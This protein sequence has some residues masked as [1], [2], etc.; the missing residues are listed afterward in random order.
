MNR[1]VVSQLI[2]IVLLSSFAASSAQDA[3]GKPPAIRYGLT[4][5]YR[6]AGEDDFKATQKYALECFQEEET[7]N[8]LY[9]TQTGALSVLSKGLFKAGEG[10]EKGPLS[11]H[12]FEITVRKADDK[13]VKFGVECFLDENNK[14]LIYISQTGS[15][16]VV[17]AKYAKPTT[18]KIKG[19]SRSHGMNLKVR[20]AGD[21][22]FTKD[23]KKYGIDVV[24]DDN[25][26]NILYISETGSIAAVPAALLK[27]GGKTDWKDSWQ[28]GLELSVRGP[29]EK[30]FSKDTKKYGVEV[31]R[32]ADNGCMVYI[33]ENGNIA[34]VPSA[35]AK[36]ITGKSTDPRLQRGMSLGVRKVDE[37]DFT[38]STKKIGVE[39]YQDDNNANLVYVSD[40]GNLAVVAA[41]EE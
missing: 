34:V 39:V 2:L 36:F 33:A 37:K 26:G 17:A 6:K 7:G 30:D 41:K 4:L 38:D 12:G 21:K 28:Y 1:V 8:G 22:D 32:D 18:G 15:I 3:K 10:K 24:E 29:A 23:S 11:Q 25:N 9:I 40:T 31:Y 20:K 13:T 16:A 27:G 19:W 14:D 35:W 5:K